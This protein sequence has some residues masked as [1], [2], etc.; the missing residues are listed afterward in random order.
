MRQS[1]LAFAVGL[2]LLAPWAAS[3]VRADDDRWA[4]FRFL[5]G[6]W[7]SE[8]KP[9]EG[10]GR[11][12][13]EPELQGKVLVRRNVANVP[14]VQ[15]RAAVKHEDLMIVYP[16]PRSRQIRAS[17]FDNEGHVIDYSVNALPDKKGLVFAS[18]PKLPGPCFRLTYTKAGESEVALKFEIAPPG[19]PDQFRLYLQG[20]VKRDE[21]AK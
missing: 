6:T 4:D 19:K 18:D 8:A 20:L 13:L 11:F 10:S 2:S 21:S 17:Y 3:A 1:S 16:D 7:V 9:G 14:A 12:S 5:I 15:G